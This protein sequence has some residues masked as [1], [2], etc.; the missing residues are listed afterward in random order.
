MAILHERN[1]QCPVIKAAENYFGNHEKAMEFLWGS[2]CFPMDDE[3]AMV[4]LT[5]FIDQDPT[6]VDIKVD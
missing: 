4:Q 2:T 6:K 5:D 3:L 1:E